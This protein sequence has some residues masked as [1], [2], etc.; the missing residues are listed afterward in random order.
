MEI[1]NVYFLPNFT[2]Y[3][4]D[5]LIITNFTTQTIQI[6]NFTNNFTLRYSAFSE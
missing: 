2:I 4:D 1:P 6:S 5:K 3:F